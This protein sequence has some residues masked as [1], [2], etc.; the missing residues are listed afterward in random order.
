MVDVQI[1]LGTFSMTSY[2]H[3][4]IIVIYIYQLYFEKKLLFTTSFF[5][6]VVFYVSA[7]ATT[8]LCLHLEDT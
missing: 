6:L 4:L 3:G 7:P 8:K 5:I 1:V 2:K